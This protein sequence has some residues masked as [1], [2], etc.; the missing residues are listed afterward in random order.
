MASGS[1]RKSSWLLVALALV[2]VV[3]WVAMNILGA[4]SST[5]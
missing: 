3:G 2:L 1:G 4:G 5:R